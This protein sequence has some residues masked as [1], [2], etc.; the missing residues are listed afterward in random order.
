MSTPVREPRMARG[1]ARREAL[2]DSAIRLLAREGARAVTHRAVAA[3]A[4]TTHGTAR[5]YFGTLDQLLDEALQRLAARQIEQVRALLSP[6]PDADVPQRI[7]RLARYFTEALASD[8]D[9]GIARYELF[10]EVAR[11]PQLRASLDEWGST[12][13]AAFAAELRGA[14]ATDPEARAAD[15]LTLVNGLALEQLALPTDDF[16]TTRLRPAI[17]RFFPLA[18]A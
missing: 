3:E 14:G 7:T 6:L 11:R 13:R 10:L 17:A 1:A 5:Y 9:A 16:E 2:L 18:E 15:L 8:R 12:Q 4:G